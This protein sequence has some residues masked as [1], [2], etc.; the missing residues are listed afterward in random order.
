MKISGLLRVCPLFFSPR[1]VEEGRLPG[2]V[3]AGSASSGVPG[4][5]GRLP[6]LVIHICAGLLEE[7]IECSGWFDAHCLSEFCAGEEPPLQQVPFHVVRAGDLYGFAIKAINK[8]SQGFILS[9]DDGL[10]SRLG[11]WVSPRRSERTYE[12]VLQ[13]S[14]RGD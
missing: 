9:L 3:A 14:P 13:I 4:S 10:E 7:S 1:H 6:F 11:L 12:L 2:A 8:L 5:V